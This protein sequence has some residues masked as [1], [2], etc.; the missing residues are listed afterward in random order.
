MR[1]GHAGRLFDHLVA[2]LGRD[3]VFMDVETIAPGADFVVEIE[4]AIAGLRRADRDDRAS[5]VL[6][7]DPDGKSRLHD[8]DD[9]VRLE[10]N[11]GARG[12]SS[13]VP[14]PRSR[15]PPCLRSTGSPG[16]SPHW[17]DAM[18]SCSTTRAGT[19]TSSG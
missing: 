18:P 5:L 15:G 7:G 3:H 16:R 12:R 6:A 1:A 2:Q 9:F 11:G 17:H 10:I 14:D 19:T 8:P 13:A 4:G